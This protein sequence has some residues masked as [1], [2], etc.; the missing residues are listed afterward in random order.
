MKCVVVPLPRVHDYI[1]RE[2][3]VLRTG[4]GEIVGYRNECRHL[5]I[6]IDGMTRRFFTP[7]GKRLLCALH[8]AEYNLD[9][10]VC[11]RG[12]CKGKA[13]ERL[14]VEIEANDVVVVD[15]MPATPL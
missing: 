5:P 1:P 4:S 6:P 11:V 9:D 14:R 15:V 12:P 3:L 8:G 13:L 2:A 10:G 7:D